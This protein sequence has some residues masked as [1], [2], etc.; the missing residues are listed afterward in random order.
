[1]KAPEN[2]KNAVKYICEFCY[3]DTCK[4]S[5]YDKHLLTPKHEKNS[6]ILQI[7]QNTTYLA[8]ENA[9]NK[10]YNCN[11]GKSYKHHSSLWNHKKKC[12]LPNLE[13]NNAATDSSANEIKLLTNLVIELVKSNN[14]LQ[15]Q[16][17]DV[18]KKI[19]PTTNTTNSH[20]TNSLNKTFN[21]Q[22][23][24][25]ETCKDAM[26][27]MDFVDSIKLQLSDLEKVGQIGY[28]EGISNIIT[29]NLKALDVTQRPIHCTDKK[30]ETL[31]IKDE[32]KWEKENEEKKKLRKVIKK[33]ANKNIMLLQKFKE[34]HPDCG[35][36]ASKYSD[37]YNKIIIESMDTDK[38]NENKIIKNISNITTIDK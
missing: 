27:I 8:P 21:L 31:Y 14:D 33:V 10:N 32:D 28:V 24:L 1:M 11:C 36:S 35:K 22:F 18:C 30:R 17:I 26:N 20:N 15:K 9:E 13:H 38:E 29:T 25:N 7:L 2:A 5:N 34:V 16:F 12:I 19:Q 6:K 23:F 4:K 37:Q 3:F